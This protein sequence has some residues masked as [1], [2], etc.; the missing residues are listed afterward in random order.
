MSQFVP[1]EEAE[2]LLAEY[3]KTMAVISVGEPVSGSEPELA[4]GQGQEQE[5]LAAVRELC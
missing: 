4:T 2:R 1:P 3:E 5:L